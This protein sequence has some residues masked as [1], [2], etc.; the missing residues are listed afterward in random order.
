MRTLH[1]ERGRL[2]LHTETP[3][4]SPQPGE[5]LIQITM[6]GICETD[7]QLKAGYMDFA[8]VLGHEFVGM[9]QSGRFAGQRVV[10]EINCCLRENCEGCA[11]FGRNHCPQRTV[12]G[13]L[14]RSG[15]FA[16]FITLPEENLLPVPD[17]V[18]D[19]H[20]VLVE[21]LAAAFEILT[22]IPDPTGKQVAIFGDGRLGVVC[23]LVL[24]DAGADVLL[25]GKHLSKLKLAAD[26]LDLKTTLLKELPDKAPQLF[27][28]TV[29]CTGAAT[30]LQAAINHTRP[31]GIVIL[32]TTLA[33]PHTLPLSPVVI[34]EQTL[35]GSRC[36]PFA[37]ALAAIAEEKFNLAALIS[38]TYPLEEFAA[39]FDRSTDGGSYKVLLRI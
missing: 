2:S 26:E 39:A 20:A 34:H 25:V 12:L 1:C 3:I 37:P 23:G 21:P 5:V 30:G 31:R 8:G 18:P 13:I 24:R 29:D 16:D 38:A 28:L 4:P 22:Q 7:H 9:A 27:D 10:G 6:A 17:H 11:K 19:E 15:A 35:I 32:K 33:E 14:N 36:G